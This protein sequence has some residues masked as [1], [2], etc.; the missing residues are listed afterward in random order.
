M[1]NANINGVQIYYESYGEGFPLIFAYDVG[2]STVYWR[3]QIP[4]Q[5][6]HI[7]ATQEVR[8]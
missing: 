6:G 5:S 1:P 3:S 7:T 4:G 2:G 8:C